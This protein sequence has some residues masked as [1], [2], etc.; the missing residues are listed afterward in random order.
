M[1]YKEIMGRSSFL[2]DVPKDKQ[3]LEGLEYKEVTIDKTKLMGW[4][5]KDK[6]F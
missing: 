3:T 4:T 1:T 6:A 2:V 5:F